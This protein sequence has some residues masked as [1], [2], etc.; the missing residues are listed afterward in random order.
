MAKSERTRCLRLQGSSAHKIISSFPARFSTLLHQQQPKTKP[1]TDTTIPK[2]APRELKS[3][4]HPYFT[5]FEEFPSSPLL[6]AGVSVFMKSHPQLQSLPCSVCASS[7][8]NY[9]LDA[10]P[11]DSVSK[12]SS[13]PVADAMRLMEGKIDR[14]PRRHP[15]RSRKR[16]RRPHWDSVWIWEAR[17]T[18]MKPESHYLIQSASRSKTCR[19]SSSILLSLRKRVDQQPPS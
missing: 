8:L 12:I 13:P 3:T 6:P 10:K 18:R 17:T 15:R 7:F 19:S 11:A 1:S 16:H 14:H 2:M 4:S 5:D 9:S